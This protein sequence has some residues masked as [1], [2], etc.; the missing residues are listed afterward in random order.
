MLFDINKIATTPTI[1][2]IDNPVP[3]LI[4]SK[5]FSLLKP[6]YSNVVFS[7]YLTKNNKIT[8]ENIYEHKT[9]IIL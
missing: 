3:T 5:L 4:A 8:A 7:K 1:L 2:N 9:D 6:K